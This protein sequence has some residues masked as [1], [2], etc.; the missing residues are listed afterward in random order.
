MSMAA[1]VQRIS[2]SIPHAQA[3]YQFLYP[4]SAY[5]K[6]TQAKE[7]QFGSAP[8]VTMKHPQDRRAMHQPPCLIAAKNELQGYRDLLQLIISSGHRNGSYQEILACL[9]S[10]D[11]SFSEWNK[12][13]KFREKY[14]SLADPLAS[15]GW[16][17][18]TRVYTTQRDK[19]T[20]P[21][22]RNRLVAFPDKPR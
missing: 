5:E 15:I 14:V 4:V 20:K 21:S 11:F 3:P 13:R 16:N 19:P 18:A 1:L 17:R 12:F 6:G 2:W 10:L 7:N 22:Y 8:V 9:L